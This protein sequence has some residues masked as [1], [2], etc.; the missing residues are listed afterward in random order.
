MKFFSKILF[1]TAIMAVVAANPVSAQN[2]A[3]VDYEGILDLMPE[4]KKVDADMSVLRT[5]YTKKVENI[6]KKLQVKYQEAQALAE[7][8]KLTADLE[9]SYTVQIQALEEEADKTSSEADTQL[10]KRRGELL[11]P[12]LD[13][14]E[15]AINEIA[16]EKNISYVLATST[17]LYF[18]GTDITP[19]VKTKLG[20]K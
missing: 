19:D 12:I 18:N 10:N 6:K 1:L 11:K 8:G 9:K 17:L 13:R 5:Q 16:K 4:L 2:V 20:L 7:Q 3:H 14:V 15:G